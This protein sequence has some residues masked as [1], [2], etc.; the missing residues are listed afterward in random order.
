MQQAVDAGQGDRSASPAPGT[1]ETALP[2]LPLRAGFP[3][4]FCVPIW[5]RSACRITAIQHDIL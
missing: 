2:I 1:G 4:D 5:K 3:G